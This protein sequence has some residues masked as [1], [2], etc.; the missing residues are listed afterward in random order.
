MHYREQNRSSSL[1]ELT[2]SS[3]IDFDLVLMFALNTHNLKLHVW[4]INVMIY[5]LMYHT[6]LALPNL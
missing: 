1:T 3:P 4:M 6:F 2:Y 5:S